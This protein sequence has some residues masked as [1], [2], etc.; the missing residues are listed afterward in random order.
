MR[1]NNLYSTLII[2]FWA[3]TL[4]AAPRLTVVAVVDGLTTENLTMLRPYWSQGGLRTM[5]EEAFQTS[6][7]YPHLVYGGNE[8]TATLVTGVTPDRHGYSMDNYFMRRDRQIHTMLEDDAIQGIGTNMHCSPRALLS[9]T[10]TDKMRLMYPNA[11]IYAI[12]LQ[13]ETTILLAGHS[14]NACCWLDAEQKQWIAT[15]AYSEGLPTAA[16]EQNQSGRITTLAAR[17]WMP[18]MDIPAY[19]APT[20]QERKKGFSY[21]VGDVL[22]RSP[23]ANTLVIELAL[24]LQQSENIGTDATPDMLMLQLNSLSPSAQSDRIASAEHEDMYLRLNQDLGYLMEQL[25]RRIGKANYQVLVVGRPVLGTDAQTLSDIHMPVQ[26]FNVDRA[27][28]LTGTYLMALYGHERWVDGG[29]GQSIYLN[30]TLIEQKRLSLETLQR[31]VANFLMDFEGVQ[32]AMPGHEAFHYPVLGATLNKRFTGDVV[33]MLQPGWRLMQD[34]K[35]ALEDDIETLRVRKRKL[36]DEVA[37]TL[38]EANSDA[39]TIRDEAKVQ[40]EV[41]M[42]R[43]RQNA[44][45]IQAQREKDLKEKEKDLKAQKQAL[46]DWKKHA[47]DFREKL[48][49]AISKE[50]KGK[51]DKALEQYKEVSDRKRYND[52]CKVIDQM[53]QSKLK[54]KDEKIL[55][56]FKRRAGVDFTLPQAPSIMC[57]PKFSRR[58]PDIPESWLDGKDSDD[59]ER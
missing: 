12:G 10:M 50:Y 34:E 33:F 29:Y 3:L 11:K 55:D 27:A 5:S 44:Q 14:A 51:Y 36:K 54:F 28:A 26:Q 39:Q 41:I 15:T 32:I 49:D 16:F 56:Y 31:Q 46:G 17:M 6:V 42:E 7:T 18:R 38:T 40:A 4:T 52:Y 19:T 25:D 48:N 24:A 43:A 22:M 20:A 35:K 37:T 1:K 21:E 59:F 53:A 23:E 30:R 58:L 13:P 57:V 45:Q 2:S 8:T 47:E 9:Q